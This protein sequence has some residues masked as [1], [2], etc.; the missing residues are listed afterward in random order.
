MTIILL[1]VSVLLYMAI[2][3]SKIAGKLG[4]PAL[5]MFIAIG[6]ISGS[7]GIGGIY[8]DNYYIAQFIGIIA[9]SYILFSG[10]ISVEIEDIRPIFLKDW[11]FPR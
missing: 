1:I 8:F 2:F 6:I 4:I 3:A 7:D 9:L 11:L 5:L 10:G